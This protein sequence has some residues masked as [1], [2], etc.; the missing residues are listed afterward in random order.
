MTAAEREQWSAIKND[1]D[2]EKF[3]LNFLAQRGPQ[4]VADVD[5]ASSMADKYL[6]VGKIPG[7]KSLRGKI[8]IM[9]GP[10][11]AIKVDQ[12]KTSGDRRMT[13][14]S[15]ASTDGM[16]AS[17]GEMVQAANGAGADATVVNQYTFTYA[18]SKLPAGFNT[19][20]LVITVDLEGASSET[21][22]GG[23]KAAA[24]IDQLFEAA[25]RARMTPLAASN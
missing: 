15:A 24:Q 1:D 25:A 17:V 9:L 13:A 21:V 5:K 23:R 6:T 12:K 14:T 11:S 19:S 10:P 3:V 7:S 4:F 2:A 8:V 22:H 16:G 20:D 18:A